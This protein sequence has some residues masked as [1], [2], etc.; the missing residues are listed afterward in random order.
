M[1]ILI[2]GINFAPEL[3]GVG[4]YT[5][6]MA[7]WLARLGHSVTMVTAPP[8]YPSW[9]VGPGY[10]RWGWRRER[11]KGCTVIRCPLYVPRRVSGIGR[12]IHVASFSLSSIA[13]A[14]A[15]ALRAKP[16][17]VVAIAP[18]LM[19]S[20]VT[21]AIARLSGAKTWLHV[22]DFEVE[23]AAQLDLFPYIG[24]RRVAVAF[25]R[26]LLQRF[27][28]VSSIS[29]KMVDRLVVKGAAKDR[30][31]LFPNWVDIDAIRPI[32]HDNPLR[33]ELQLP[34][35][36]TIALYAGSMGE[37]H[38][39]EILIDAARRLARADDAQSASLLILVAGDGPERLRLQALAQDLPNIRFIDLQ[40]VER[41]N[42]LLNLADIH[43]LP[44]RADI[45][46]LV[47]PSKLGPMLASG[48]PVIATVA[49]ETQ[50]SAAL[51]GSG[52]IVPP[53]DAAALVRAIQRL[54]ADPA[55]RQRLGRTARHQA[56][57]ELNAEQVLNQMEG[58]LRTLAGRGEPRYRDA[59]LIAVAPV[60]EISAADPRGE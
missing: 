24:L 35:G 41:L 43:L 12:L 3:T 39:L 20:P 60:A 27:N 48:R 11:W 44:Q 19:S 58:R 51:A 13:A 6:E 34:E 47:M 36:R 37:K 10:R 9:Q 23:V 2:V 52:V 46:D 25:E 55:L 21:L 31:V 56:E 22:Q 49:P 1:R 26:Y 14:I 53:G 28:L 7:A 40:P 45:A 59:A 42:E 5:G 16:D 30:C 57:S 15:A 50:L 38:G 4:K 17:L 29:S 54:I 32:D 33:R 18:T 8:Y